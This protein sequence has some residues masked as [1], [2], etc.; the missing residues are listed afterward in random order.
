M[1][2]RIQ[3]RRGTAA[4]WASA[5]PTLAAGELGYETDTNQI[6]IGTATTAWND[7]AYS[8]V[9]QA[10]I[11]S[12]LSGI[13]GLAPETL[14]TLNELA[15]AIG[16]D[17]NFVQTIADD[18]TAVQNAAQLYTDN[19][20]TDHD[21]STNVHGIADTAELETK[22]GAQAKATAAQANAQSYTDTS[23]ANL[24]DSSPTTL[25]TL[26]ELAAAL[27]DDANFAT[28][29]AGQIGE[30]LSYIV[31][32]ATNFATANTVTEAN[33]I[34]IESDTS[35]W[36]RIGDG[37]TAYND[38]VLIGQPYTDDA[39]AVFNNLTTNVHGITDTANLVY[40]SAF[41]QLDNTVTD[42]ISD[43]L[44]VHGIANT[45]ELVTT[46]DLSSH[47]SDTTSVHGIANTADLVI[48]ADLAPYA[49]SEGAAL[50][51]ASV[52]G[53]ATLPA[54]TT[55]GTVT[56]TEI[57]H[58]SGVTSGIQGQLGTLDSAVTTLQ[59]D[60]QDK[61]NSAS[62]TFTGTVVLPG[63]TS[64]GDVS[65]TEIGYVNGVT[66][67]IQTQ[68][69]AKLNS[70][71][72]STTYVAQQGGSVS[73]LSAVGQTALGATTYIGTVTPA[74]IA[75]LSGVTSAI[76][77]QIDAKAPIASP[78]FTGTV[79]GVTKAM[80]GL[81]DV[82]N[83]TD[84]GKP[85]STATQSALDLKANLAGATFNGNVVVT[86]NFTVTGTTTTVNT[87]NFTTTDPLI[88]LG[89]GN[90]GNTADLGFVANF[91]DG[92]YQHTGLVRDSS[93][94]TW[95]LFKGVTDEPTSTVN[96]AQGTLDNISVNNVT[97]AGVVFSD[98]IQTKQ[99]VPSISTFVYKTASYTL[100]ALD[101]RDEIIEVSSASATTVT[102][103]ADSSVNY[104]IGSS[105]DIL[106][107]STGQVTIAAGAG[108]T[109]NATPGLKLRTQWS[110][111]T[112][113]K[114]A[115]N[116]WVVYGDLTA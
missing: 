19:A 43:T 32:T 1:A 113:L 14:D 102:I 46:S 52:V 84:A 80:V 65:S 37:V 50:A 34:Y 15:A 10:Y 71:T 22:T 70:S 53:S 48:T 24:V 72:A 83:T 104:P 82:D 68:L 114:R 85:I 45:A 79:S 4:E 94:N 51:N 21:V 111:A 81:G 49:V 74:E 17:P 61:A 91:N 95:K 98:G 54:A 55:I 29:V 66:G 67:A 27:G 39:I 30:K 40:A 2:V 36:V 11:D 77:T 110:S 78:T 5:N 33:T 20:L 88:Y 47:A 101:L 86:G 92:T 9:S 89:E 115:A 31:D 116:T 38:A 96:F 100:D 63:D 58:L 99:G 60:L 35:G 106:Q 103:P 112:L 25:N 75:T 69:D 109:V 59:S 6:K 64:I 42:H 107:T 57:G 28:T 73:N 90:A 41:N 108:V 7:L 26:N 56:A 97:A 93:D 16:D 44:N 12:A 76:Q 23:I 62:P 8:G 13:V 3:F 18:I 87:A 105:I